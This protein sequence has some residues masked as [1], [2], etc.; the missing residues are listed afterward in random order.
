MPSLTEGTHPGGFLVWE[1]L[2]DYTRETITVAAGTLA[3]GTVLGKITGSGK[4]AAHDP[5]AIDG[6]ETA[7]AVLWGKADASAGDAPA[8]ALVR[9]PAI[10]NPHDLVFTGTLAEAEITAAHAALLAAGILVR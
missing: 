4:Y 8:V 7:V 6:T 2:R 10:V 9:G 1:V 3:P 5:A